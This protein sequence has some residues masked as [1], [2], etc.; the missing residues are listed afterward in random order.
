LGKAVTDREESPVATLKG[1]APDQL[2]ILIVDQVDA[3]SEVSGRNGMVRQ[4][5]L[6][7]VDDV[8]NFGR[9]VIVI[10]CR[11]F[12]LECDQRL[13]ALKDALGVEHIDVQL[14]TWERDVEPLLTSK[15][16]DAKQFS[17]KQR[18]LLRLPI[19]LAIFLETFDGTETAFAS[20]NDLFARLLERKGRSIRTDRQISWE[21]SRR[22]SS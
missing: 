5:V 8:R 9:V 12:D 4:A 21:S 15:S 2:S 17:E 6:K 16:I 20:R 18:E 13:K 7:L 3:V 19:N 14:L 22:C 11:T 10:A 1:M